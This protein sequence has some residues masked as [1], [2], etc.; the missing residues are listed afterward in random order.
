MALPIGS[1][2]QQK[3]LG[4]GVIGSLESN[5][6]TDVVTA[7]E[8]IPF[9]VALDIKGGKAVVATKAPIFGIAMKR[10]YA[11]GNDYNAIKDDH[12]YKGEKI[13]AVRKGGI[14]VPITEDVNRY[15]QATVNN[16]GTFRPARSGEPVVG[17][18][19]TNGDSGST[20][21]IQIELTDMGTTGTGASSSSPAPSAPSS[22]G[23]RSGSGSGSSASGSSSTS[24]SGSH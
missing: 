2:Y 1:M 12:Y 5:D 24:G 8:D 22:S 4:N 10:D 20:A 9:G 16:D 19:I 13:S 11:I 6:P 18:F 15:D 3:A 14:S 23:S 21:I 17:R 7:G